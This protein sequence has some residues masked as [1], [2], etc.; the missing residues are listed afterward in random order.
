MG[1]SVLE[2]V[3]NNRSLAGKEIRAFAMQVK[4]WG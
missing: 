1:L 4:L 2:I 3:A